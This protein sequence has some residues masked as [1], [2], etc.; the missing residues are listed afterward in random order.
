MPG[1]HFARLW[2]ADGPMARHEEAWRSP[3]AASPRAAHGELIAGRSSWRDTLEPYARADR[4]RSL[5]FV[6]TS[7]LP[8]LVL[9]VLMDLAIGISYLLTLALAI[10]AAGFLVRT[11]IVFHDCTH[12]SFLGSKRANRWLGTSLGL[13]VFMPFE[14]WKHNHAVHHATAGDLDRRG[15]GDVRTLTVAEYHARRWRGR[16]AYR[17]FRNPLV[18]F[19]LGPIFTLVLQPRTVPRSARPRIKRSVTATNVALL[20]LVGGLCW[21][22]GWRHYLLVQ[23]PAIMLAGAAGIWLFYVQHQFEDAYWENAPGWSYTDAAL[24]GSSYLKLPKV[25]QF[26]SGNIG[27]HHVHHLSARIPSYNLPRAHD[28]NPIFHSVTTVSITDGMRAVRLKL[29]DQDRCR[30]VSFAQARAD[31]RGKRA[32]L[33]QRWVQDVSSARHTSPHRGRTAPVKSLRKGR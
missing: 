33:A 31:R 20:V 15:V 6:L 23:A 22:M 18:M 19:G 24:R 4:G 17:L 2:R 11:F 7:V 26:F 25:L 21:L 32:P 3:Q 14:Y 5:L 10:P 28:E 12:G 9:F 16:L 13:L 1:R 29:Y 30:M 8:Y 27:F